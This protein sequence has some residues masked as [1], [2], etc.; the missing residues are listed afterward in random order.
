MLATN[1]D[2][3]KKVLNLEIA[4]QNNSNEIDWS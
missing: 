3:Y 2:F 1:K 4:K